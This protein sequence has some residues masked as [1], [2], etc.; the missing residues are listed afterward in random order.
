[1][2]LEQARV[3]DKKLITNGV[4]SKKNYLKYQNTQYIVMYVGKSK[5]KI[6]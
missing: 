3:M 5:C 2:S 1:M 4:L 6:R